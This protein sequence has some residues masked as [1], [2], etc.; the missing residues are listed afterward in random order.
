LGNIGWA[1]FDE[2]M[3]EYKIDAL[4]YSLEDGFV[5]II[6]LLKVL[7]TQLVIKYHFGAE[8]QRG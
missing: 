8:D 6:T 5:G 3:I 1:V 7:F 4:T 2:P